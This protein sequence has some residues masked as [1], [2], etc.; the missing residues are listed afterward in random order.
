[1]SQPSQPREPDSVHFILLAREGMCLK[2]SQVFLIQ[3]VLSLCETS[4]S[5]SGAGMGT[6]SSGPSAVPK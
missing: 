2:V 3:V 6:G 4:A 1:M 5:P